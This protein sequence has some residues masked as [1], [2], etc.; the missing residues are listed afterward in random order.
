MAIGCICGCI[1]DLDTFRPS[2]LLYMQDKTTQIHSPL[3]DTMAHNELA[4]CS[5]LDGVS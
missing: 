2:L 5:N 3:M 4:F 1:L